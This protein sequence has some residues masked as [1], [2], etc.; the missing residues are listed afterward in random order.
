MNDNQPGDTNFVN[1]FN[2]GVRD[3]NL[4]NGGMGTKGGMTR[5]RGCG[6]DG[7]LAVDDTILSESC[8]APTIGQTSM[9]TK[10]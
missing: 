3:E 7:F 2:G 5:R 8:L 4:F 6:Q 1:V 9:G 10:G